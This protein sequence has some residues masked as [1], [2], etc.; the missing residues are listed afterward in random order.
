MTERNLP[1][2]AENYEPIPPWRRTP[3]EAKTTKKP[4][5]QTQNESSD[6]E[7]LVFVRIP[8]AD[9]VSLENDA[10]AW[11]YFWKLYD[12]SRDAQQ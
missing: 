12:E 3:R 1:P 8:G 7:R 11:K 4:A 2:D 10:E 9:W 5:E 6:A